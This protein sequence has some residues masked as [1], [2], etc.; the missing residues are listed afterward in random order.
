MNHFYLVPKVQTIFPCHLAAAHLC[1][2][3]YI[4]LHIIQIIFSGSNSH[5]LISPFFC[6]FIHSQQLYWR[7]CF[8]MEMM[9]VGDGCGADWRP[10]VVIWIPCTKKEAVYPDFCCCR[11]KGVQH[12][13]FVFFYVS[14][15]RVDLPWH[16]PCIIKK[17]SSH[18]TWIHSFMFFCRVFFFHFWSEALPLKF[19]MS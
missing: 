11:L 7:Y 16:A 2:H 15:F 19:G 5:D 18:Q 8:L 12:T 6:L 1:T 9:D 17:S 14:F 4:N 13:G 3:L 10:A